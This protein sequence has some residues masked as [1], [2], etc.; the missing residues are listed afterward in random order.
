MNKKAKYSS[1]GLDLGSR[2][3][4]RIRVF[5]ILWTTS[6]MDIYPWSHLKMCCPMSCPK[7][8]SYV[9][10]FAKKARK[11]ETCYFFENVSF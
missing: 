1:I 8:V 9:K 2:P 11:K 5:L 6:I 7:A 10:K 4:S 3:E